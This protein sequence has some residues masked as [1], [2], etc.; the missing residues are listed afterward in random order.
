M[1]RNLHSSTLDVLGL[2]EGIRGLCEEF[3]EQQ[4]VHVEFTAD[5]VPRDIPPLTSLCLYRIAQE[6]L[7]NVK[8]H[9]GAGEAV[10]A[11]NR[12]GNEIVLS[13][14]DKGVG[15]DTRER[16][17]KVGLGLRSMQERLRVVGGTLEVNSNNGHG[18]RILAR[19]PL[20]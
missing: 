7:R 11:L 8:K 4:G 18:T 12:N 6:G 5:G 2:A 10:V 19:A 20:A 1:S 9:S 13:V 15:F 16:P 14:A 3:A 17:F